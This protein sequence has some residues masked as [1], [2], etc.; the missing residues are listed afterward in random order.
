M[1]PIAEVTLIQDARRVRVAGVLDASERASGGVTVALPSAAPTGQRAVVLCYLPSAPFVRSVQSEFR[2]ADAEGVRL[3]A[4]VL[5]HL[6]MD[7][8][9]ELMVMPLPVASERTRPQAGA[10]PEAPKALASSI[11]PP[12]T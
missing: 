6:G 8:G 12:Q 1:A 4:E 3:P 9:A 5:S 11:P 7:L 2:W 10:A